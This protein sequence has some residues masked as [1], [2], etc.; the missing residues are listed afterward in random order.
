MPVLKI[1]KD[2]INVTNRVKYL[3]HIFKNDLSDNDDIECQS[4]KLLIRGNILVRK[5][6]MCSLYVKIHLF[7]T[8][9][10]PIYLCQLWWKFY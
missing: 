6:F 10:Y 8:F 1:D 4:R 3:G 7:Q 2:Q 9:C 5:F